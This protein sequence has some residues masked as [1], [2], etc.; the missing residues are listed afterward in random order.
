LT[1]L[2]LA[3]LNRATLGRHVWKVAKERGVATCEVR[4]LGRLTARVRAAVEKEG[5]R[6][7]EFAAAEADTREVRILGA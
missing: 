7:L 6:L 5:T 3:E 2:G 1:V 4:P